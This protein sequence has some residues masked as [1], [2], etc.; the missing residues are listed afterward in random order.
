MNP[1]VLF[2]RIFAKPKSM[3]MSEMLFSETVNSPMVRLDDE[4]GSIDIQGKST[5]PDPVE[6]YS[7]LLSQIIKIP[8][9]KLHTLNIRLSYI[10]T[11]SSKWMLHLFRQLEKIAEPLSAIQINWFYE[12]DDETMAMAG[13]DYRS[14]LKL[15]FNLISERVSDN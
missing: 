5:L 13:E 15:P 12:E 11:G 3:M 4:R 1:A 8:R 9:Q 10:N 14:M 2:M 6:F 7:S